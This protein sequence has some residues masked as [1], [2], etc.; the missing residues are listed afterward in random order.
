M[1]LFADDPARNLPEAVRAALETVKDPEIPAL[2]VL[3]MGVVRDVAL[4]GGRIAV[5]ITPTYSGCPAMHAIEL[6]IVRALDHAGFAN[7]TIRTSY[8]PAWTTDWLT[9]AAREKLRR[10]G[11]A[12]PA[13]SSKRAMLGDV[14]AC[15]RCGAR[16][17]EKLSEFGSTACKAIYRCLACAEPFDH[18][19]CI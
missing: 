7:A 13:A 18:F 2:N 19:K 10:S 17:T 6:D 8:A 12:P 16:R 14:V 1:P 15:P 4:E 5:T 3:E 9:D 11:I